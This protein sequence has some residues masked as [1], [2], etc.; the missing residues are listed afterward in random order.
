MVVSERR[1]VLSFGGVAQ[2]GTAVR[3]AAPAACTV[4]RSGIQSRTTVPVGVV[5]C[6]RTITWNSLKSPMLGISQTRPCWL[7]P[8]ALT[9]N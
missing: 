2:I 5:A 4:P 6:T 8:F 9:V 7:A 3:Q 1:P